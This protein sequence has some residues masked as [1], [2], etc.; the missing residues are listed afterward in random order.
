MRG[1]GGGGAGGRLGR[2]EGGK[3]KVILNLLTILTRD[4]EMV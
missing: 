3:R 1:G 2:L 4:L